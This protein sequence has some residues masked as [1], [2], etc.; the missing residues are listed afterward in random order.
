MLM[1]PIVLIISFNQFLSREY[2]EYMLVLNSRNTSTID[3]Y[4]KLHRNVDFHYAVSVL[5][6]F[7]RWL[8]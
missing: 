4:G 5:C 6:M 2:I 3:S 8:E 1:F 7:E